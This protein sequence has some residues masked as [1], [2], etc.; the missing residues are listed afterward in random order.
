MVPR[1]EYVAKLGR[2]TDVYPGS[3]RSAD[4]SRRSTRRSRR[5]SSRRP[6]ASA[7]TSRRR[8][9]RTRRRVSRSSTCTTG[10]TCST[11][12]GAFGGN[13]WRVDETL[14]TGAEDGT[15]REVIVVAIDNTSDRME[16]YTPSR[17]P[18][19]GFGG[20][21]DAYLSLV[22]TELKPRIDRDLRTMSGRSDTAILGSSLGGLISV[23]AGTTRAATFGRIGA[24]SPSTWWNGAAIVPEVLA[25][26]AVRPDVVYVDSGD[27]GS[28]RGD[29]V[30][31]TAR[32]AAAFRALGYVDGKDLLYVMQPGGQHDEASWAS[33]LPKALAFLVGSGR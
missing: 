27:G 7:C 15:I 18:D 29:D 12:S 23:R 13:E 10:R 25:M 9:R 14:D 6:A 31:N 20:K 28:G 26:G 4:P 11:A 17:D 32:L 19:E 24:M 21:G 8:T 33:R 1:T 5:P 22:A 16:E 3:P 2:T 30:A